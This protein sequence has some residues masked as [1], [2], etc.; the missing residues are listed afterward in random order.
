[1]VIALSIVAP[2]LLVSMTI[3]EQL[4]INIAE[5]GGGGIGIAAV[6]LLGAF[7][8]LLATRRRTEKAPFGS[9]RLGH[10]TLYIV[11]AISFINSWLNGRAI[12][13]F[14]FLT[15]FASIP[16]SLVGA[17][18]ATQ[19]APL[20][21]V[22]TPGIFTAF[23][24]TGLVDAHRFNPISTANVAWIAVLLLFIE[25]S[26]LPRLVWIPLVVTAAIPW[27]RTHELGPRLAGGVAFAAAVALPV[28]RRRVSVLTGRPTRWRRSATLA[29]FALGTIIGGAALQSAISESRAS[30]VNNTMVRQA[31]WHEVL[32][33]SSM[34]G[35]GIRSVDVAVGGKFT[36]TVPHNF[37]FDAILGAGWIGFGFLLVSLAQAARGLWAGNHPWNSYALGIMAINLVSGGLFRSPSL[38]LAL[39]LLIAQC[40]RPDTGTHLSVAGDSDTAGSIANAT[41]SRGSRQTYLPS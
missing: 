24:T 20:I 25:R 12:S 3:A 40:P 9:L 41:I 29:I 15:L 5:S 7:G 14:I 32:A 1:M 4:P 28:L 38:W 27:L 21:F 26:R 34:L 11:A 16:M 22:L 6:A 37:I 33:T 19:R 13:T 35:D 36:E 23:M 2:A 31:L 10:F 18:F 17:R 8:W 30:E 39:G